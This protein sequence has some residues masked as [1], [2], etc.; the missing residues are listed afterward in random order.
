M[1]EE[2]GHG[3]ATVSAGGAMGDEQSK[4]IP[5]RDRSS[6]N[7]NNVREPGT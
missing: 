3:E 7:W 5:W 4:E 1:T 6:T 2:K